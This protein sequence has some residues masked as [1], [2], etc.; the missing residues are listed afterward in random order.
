[1]KRKQK[2]IAAVLTVAG[3]TTACLFAGSYPIYRPIPFNELALNRAVG[4]VRANAD[5]SRQEGAVSLP[6]SLAAVSTTGKA[7]VTNGIIF[8]PS[9]IGRKTILPDPFN[10]ESGWVEGYGFSTRPLPTVT[11]EPAGS[12]R[13]FCMMDLSDPA[14]TPDSGNNGRQ[15]AVDSHIDKQWYGIDSFS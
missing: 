7:Y 8:F 1:M 13:F 2:V 4:W 10:S 9:W 12:D 11:S 6:P 5:T 3:L 15:M 14:H